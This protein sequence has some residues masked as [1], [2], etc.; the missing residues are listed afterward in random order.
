MKSSDQFYDFRIRSQ[1]H[2]QNI[3]IFY[4][5]FYRFKTDKIEVIAQ[6]Q[7]RKCN[8]VFIVCIG[9]STGMHFN[10]SDKVLALKRKIKIPCQSYRYSVGI[11]FS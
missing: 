1:S 3:I 7:R 6:I 5:I 10:G 11:E 8:T 4:F 2:F 9:F